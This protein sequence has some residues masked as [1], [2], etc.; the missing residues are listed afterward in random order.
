MGREV[1]ICERDTP[2]AKIVPIEPKSAAAIQ[3]ATQK[4]RHIRSNLSVSF[5]VQ[6]GLLLERGRR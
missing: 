6:E 3:P 5:D 2:V 4:F 1:T